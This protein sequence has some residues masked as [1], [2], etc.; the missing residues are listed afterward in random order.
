MA[1]NPN[2]LLALLLAVAA[3][4]PNTV[5]AQT[6][7]DTRSSPESKPVSEG[8]TW[9]E[10]K[11][12]RYKAAWLED[13]RR[14]GTTGL[15]QDFVAS[16]EA[17]IASGCTTQGHVCPRTEAELDLANILTMQ[18]MNFG[19]ASTFLPFACPAPALLPRK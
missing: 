1:L 8:G 17:F 16:H 18:A 15:S 13:L 2:I 4:A 9:P 3:S 14:R 7:P 12:S 5:T 6:P 10:I 11:C 19:T